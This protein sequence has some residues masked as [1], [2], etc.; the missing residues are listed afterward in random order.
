MIWSCYKQYLFVTNLG[1]DPG[2][3]ANVNVN[4]PGPRKRCCRE[5]ATDRSHHTG[6][7]YMCSGDRRTMFGSEVDY[8]QG[9]GTLQD[10]CV[11]YPPD[12][13]ENSCLNLVLVL[14]RF[15]LGLKIKQGFKVVCIYPMVQS[16]TKNLIKNSTFLTRPLLSNSCHHL[17]C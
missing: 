4:T 11:A 2:S 5:G 9:C 10:W 3:I 15:E 16:P 14:T 17:S 1:R 13:P 6:F 8:G 12:D 7:S